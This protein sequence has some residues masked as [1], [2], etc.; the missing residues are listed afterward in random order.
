MRESPMST[1]LFYIERCF[2]LAEQGRHTVRPNPV[3][4]CVIIN[5]GCVVGEG[6]HQVAGEAHAEVVALQ[7]AGMRARNATVYISLEPCVHQGRTGPCTDAL[8]QAG[9]SRVVYA[10][11][12]PN[13]LVEG[14]GL[15]A[16]RAAGIAVDG[17]LLEHKA[18][19]L[20]PGF[21]KRMR[22]GL[23]YI[24]CKMG[25]S[26]DGR[27]AMPSGESKWIT[28]AEAR[29]DVQQLRARSCAVLTGVGTILQD[30]PALDVRLGGFQGKQPLRVVL[31]SKL[32][33][34]P[35]A[36]IF[37]G[38]GK[39]VLATGVTNADL[40]VHL[41]TAANSSGQQQLALHVCAGV[42]G[43]VD[44]QQLLRYLA[45]AHDCNEIL[46][47]AGAILSGAML[48][49]GLVDEIVTYIAPALLGSAAQ[50]LFMLPAIE[51]L[52]ERI[53]LQFLD[54][55]MLGKDCRIRSLVKQPE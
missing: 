49:A 36:K 17:P 7:Q 1:D 2:E 41:V 50:P 18:V 29:A 4:G 11:Q 12:D 55:A 6:W 53:Q 51:H 40:A 43:K 44:L 45:T 16:L 54:V 10:M 38:E 28:G 14:K 3:V 8:V 48:R 27:T 25:M 9:V 24:R 21:V 39:V 37:Q 26:L 22:T 35:T 32:R 33:T 34:P 13:P 19:A 23:P 52:H 31:D 5:D 46:L 15:A 42:D 30:D 47:E 20:N